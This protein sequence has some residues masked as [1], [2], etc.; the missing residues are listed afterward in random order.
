MDRKY[1]LV[2][3]LVA[4]VACFILFSGINFSVS[5]YTERP[6]YDD[7]VEVMILSNV[8]GGFV[9]VEINHTW[10]RPY[11]IGSLT[12]IDRVYV[13]P[14]GKAAMTFSFEWQTSDVFKIKWRSLLS[15]GEFQVK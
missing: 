9:T 13:P 4:L 15:S 6:L 11:S 10:M 8:A 12:Q 3:I 14:F 7:I 5:G 1:V 2:P